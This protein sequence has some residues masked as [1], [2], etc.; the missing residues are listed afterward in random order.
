MK[1]EREKALNAG[2][3]KKG[4]LLLLIW[5]P[6]RQIGYAPKRR[7]KHGSPGGE[8]GLRRK[9]GKRRKNNGLRE[10][11]TD[12]LEKSLIRAIASNLVSRLRGEG[13]ERKRTRTSL[14]N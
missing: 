6:A 12:R 9:G 5:V 8:D 13:P 3:G 14:L 1:N 7:K 10:E 11:L 2:G 4:N